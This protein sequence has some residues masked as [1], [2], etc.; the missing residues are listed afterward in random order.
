MLSLL[1]CPST[2][3]GESVLLCKCCSFSGP[4][5]SS[6]SSLGSI[7]KEKHHVTCLTRKAASAPEISQNY[8]SIVAGFRGESE[9]V[10]LQ[11]NMWWVISMLM[12]VFGD[13]V[14]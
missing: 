12:Q 14:I 1:S 4:W 8:R 5:S 13:S 7:G 9:G 2:G 11:T 10:Q 3:V 6:L